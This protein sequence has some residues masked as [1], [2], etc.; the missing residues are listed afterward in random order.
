LGALFLSSKSLLC[1]QS[2]IRTKLGFDD[3]LLLQDETL[4]L[5]QDY[6]IKTTQEQRKEQIQLRLWLPQLGFALIFT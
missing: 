5:K 3:Q 4:I 2:L 1:H 6:S